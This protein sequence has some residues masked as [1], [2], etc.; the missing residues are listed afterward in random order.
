MLKT[1]NETRH[2]ELFESA[3][4]KGADLGAYVRAMGWVKADITIARAANG[5]VNRLPLNNIPLEKE[6]HQAFLS[7][8]ITSAESAEV[9]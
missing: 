9:L 7:A 6:L 1:L 4:A 5:Y 3:R 2:A 8:A